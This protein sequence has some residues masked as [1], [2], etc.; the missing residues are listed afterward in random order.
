MEQPKSILIQ[1]INELLLEIQGD[2]ELFTCTFIEETSDKDVGR[3]Y[4]L[5][6]KNCCH[7]TMENEY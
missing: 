1:F 2:F 4:Y 6:Y 3:E 7:K 5:E